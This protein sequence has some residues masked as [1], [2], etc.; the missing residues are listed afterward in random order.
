MS[1]IRKKKPLAS[2]FRRNVTPYEQIR[3]VDNSFPFVGSTKRFSTDHRV[4]RTPLFDE[5]DIDATINDITSTSLSTWYCKTK[6]ARIDSKEKDYEIMPWKRYPKIANNVVTAKLHDECYSIDQ[7]RIVLKYPNT[8][9]KADFVAAIKTI[10]G[11]SVLFFENGKLVITGKRTPECAL[12]ALHLY[13]IALGNVSH[14]VMIRRSK[15]DISSTTTKDTSPL[16]LSYLKFLL[17]LSDF[18][19]QN[20]VC[21]GPITKEGEIVDLPALNA[22]YEDSIY[23]PDVFPALKYEFPVGHPRIPKGGTAHLFEMKAVCM[24][25]ESAKSSC[26]CYWEVLRIVKPFVIKPSMEYKESKYTNR[27]NRTMWRRNEKTTDSVTP[28]D[29]SVSTTSINRR[30]TDAISEAFSSML[31]K[32]TSNDH[33]LTNRTETKETIVKEEEE[34]EDMI[35]DDDMN[36]DMN[37]MDD[38]MIKT[39][40]ETIQRSMRPS[41]SVVN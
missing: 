5:Y 24:G 31:K 34:D 17:R 7:R 37:D 28:S 6:N 10:S 21:S 35:D 9:R 25:L 4:E 11:G 20:V 16:R 23:R 38:D 29:R 14:P 26:E 32:S 12:F 18:C 30:D 1:V 36:D 19:V 8:R 13:R 15:T 22:R 27:F 33:G 40:A 2:S 3:R 41:Y 39:I